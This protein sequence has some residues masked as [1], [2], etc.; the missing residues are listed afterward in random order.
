MGG[1]LLGNLFGTNGTLGAQQNTTTSID[2]QRMAAI[3]RHQQDL[4][5]M[6]NTSVGVRDSNKA[7]RLNLEFNINQVENG[8]ILHTRSDLTGE[9]GKTH[10]AKDIDELRDLITTLLVAKKME[11]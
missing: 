7:N 10:V 6:M 1:G 4:R 2:Q 8:W 3:A 9:V 11:N 5:E